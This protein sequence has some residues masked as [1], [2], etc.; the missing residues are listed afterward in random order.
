MLFRSDQGESDSDA[1]NV[2][3]V[4]PVARVRRRQP[5]AAI[6]PPRSP[7]AS[8]VDLGYSTMT[9]TVSECGAGPGPYLGNVIP[10]PRARPLIAVDAKTHRSHYSDINQVNLTT[11]D[12]SDRKL[13]VVPQPQQLMN[14]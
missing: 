8:S 13:V 7:V 9:E 4:V 11:D 10:L 1:D 2:R 12:A 6:P 14:D 5:P 3:L